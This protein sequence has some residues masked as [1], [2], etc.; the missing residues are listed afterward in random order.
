MNKIAILGLGLMGGSL[1]FAL[2][3]F[4][5]ASIV[6]ADVRGEVE[7]GFDGLV[8]GVV[9]ESVD[10]HVVGGECGVTFD[11]EETSASVADADGAS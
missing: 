8:C 9:F 11:F 3:G 1:A 5:G 10:E 4:K 2:R 7:E 6:G